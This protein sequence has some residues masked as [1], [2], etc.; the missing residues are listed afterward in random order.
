MFPSTE[1]AM[2][3]RRSFD[4]DKCLSYVKEQKISF[5]TVLWVMF[6]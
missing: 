4:I 1:T 3:A 6:W 5:I 2:T